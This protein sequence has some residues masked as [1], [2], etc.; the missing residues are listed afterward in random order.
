MPKLASFFRHPLIFPAVLL[1]GFALRFYALDH[2]PIHHDEAVNGWMTAETWIKGFYDY[3]PTNFHGP[4]LFY[5][6]QIAEAIGGIDIRS[7]RTVTALSGFLSVLVVWRYG[8]A[9]AALALLLSPAF[10][11][12]SRSA[13]HEAPFVLAQ[14][15]FAVHLE[16]AV[17]G[18]DRRAYWWAFLALALMMTLKETFVLLLAAGAMAVMPELSR[19]NWRARLAPM[20]APA[21][22]AFVVFLL[23]QSGWFQNTADL[24]DFFYA[25]LPWMKT[26]SDLSG[27]AKPFTHWLWL[28]FTR[29]PAFGLFLAIAVASVFARRPRLRIASRASLLLFLIYSLIPYKTP[30]CLISILWPLAFVFAEWWPEQAPR[31]RAGAFAL[32]LLA[33]GYQLTELPTLFDSDFKNATHPYFYVE[34]SRETQLL[35]RALEERARVHPEILAE[36]VGW[37]A[38][39]TWPWPWLLHRFGQQGM[40]D[41]ANGIVFVDERKIPAARA[42]Y[43]ETHHLLEMNLRAEGPRIGVFLKKS[44]GVCPPELCKIGAER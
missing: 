29:E 12:F 11:Y 30:W 4:A 28:T 41:G 44:M 14:M 25:F 10:M 27:H 20:A 6:D 23:L 32:L 42:R 1:V 15:L 22:G 18:D 3:D 9:L 35:H 34:T 8:H 33:L 19:V 43:G 26:G 38:E 31:A 40:V 2:K 5:V 21:G 13:I 36:A 39:E 16:R 37:E 17:R 7:Y 24:A